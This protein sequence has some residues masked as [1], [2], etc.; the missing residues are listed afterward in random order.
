[1]SL[2]WL[3]NA[4][5]LLRIALVV[6]LVYLMVERQF[7]AALIVL[8]IAGASDGLDGFLAKTF[9]WRSRL[10]GLLD[11]AADK[12]LLVSMF[13]TLTYLDLVPLAVTVIVIARDLVIVAG[14][15]TYQW[16]IAPVEAQPA[17]IS[18]F[19][20]GCQLAFL[21]FTVTATAYGWP[22][23]HVVT[24]VGAAVVFT[25]IVSGLNY[26]LGW[27]KRAWRVTHPYTTGA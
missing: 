26:V 7:T 16:L 5:C 17:R 14:A 19:N 2:R 12:L 20:T 13:A 21:I 24:L 1:M 23:E 25:S 11:P 6:P 18:K 9:D 15:L 4:I 3:P 10:G 27:S 22:S 8:V